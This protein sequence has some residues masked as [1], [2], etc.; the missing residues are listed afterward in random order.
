MLHVDDGQLHA[1]LD[2]E[3]ESIEAGATARIDAHFVECAVCRARLGEA[4]H[5]RGAAGAILRAADPSALR[6]REFESFQLPRRRVHEVPNHRRALQRRATALAWAA[7]LMVAC[8]IGWFARDLYFDSG[9]TGAGRQFATLEA[10]P[11]PAA[12]P[13]RPE[14]EP[15][16]E[17]ASRAEP[18]EPEAADAPPRAPLAMDAERAELTQRSAPTVKSGAGVASLAAAPAQSPPASGDFAGAEDLPAGGPSVATPLVSIPS[19]TQAG[20]AMAF[21]RGRVVNEAGAAVPHAQVAVAGLDTGTLTRADGSYSLAIPAT[22][23]RLD[24]PVSLSVRRVGFATES[25]PLDLAPGATI[26][27]DFQL[28]PETTALEGLV[29]SGSGT[30]RAERHRVAERVPATEAVETH[31]PPLPVALAGDAEPDRCRIAVLPHLRDPDVTVFTGVARSDTVPAPSAT[32]GYAGRAGE[33]ATPRQIHGQLI[34]L[35]RLGGAAAADV[36]RA[37][38]SNGTREVVIVPWAFDT[39]CRPVP[40]LTSYRW[41]P[42]GRAAFFT[43]HLRDREHWVGERPTFD[44]FV[45]NTSPYPH[46][47]SAVA[48]SGSLERLTPAQ[49]FDLY[50]ALPTWSELRREPQR[51]TARLR[52]WQRANP[53][54]A[55]RYPAGEILEAI[56]AA[57]T[58]VRDDS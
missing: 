24:E 45:G 13:A 47:T 2:R 50:Q 32:E 12:T 33:I 17:A 54:L 6:L 14:L 41:V 5:L 37:L 23:L 15:H 26:T 49:Y 35:L 16:F 11:A 52:A 28:R 40:W 27:A 3:L 30:R 36:E 46:G 48:L 34:E 43:V 18:A 1:Y 42:P 29:V 38:E 9:A 57:A 58:H 55:G 44:A 31:H 10:P 56:R 21:A 8:G 53:D 51:A 19:P 22:H 39:G 7:S 4:R 20:P 25:R